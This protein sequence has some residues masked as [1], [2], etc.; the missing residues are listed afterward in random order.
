M[1]NMIVEKITRQCCDE[2]KGDII[3]D[4][5]GFICKHC[6]QRYKKETYMDAA[7]G[8]DT[9]L[10]SIKE[11]HEA[12]VSIV[13]KRKMGRCFPKEMSQKLQLAFLSGMAEFINDY[14]AVKHKEG[15]V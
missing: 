13:A 11:L 5:Y 4:D 3:S 12:L 10:V 6:G 8:S 7:G 14:S 1:K 2:G 15:L 9:R